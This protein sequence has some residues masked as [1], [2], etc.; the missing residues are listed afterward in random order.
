M[1]LRRLHKRRPRAKSMRYMIEFAKGLY[2][3]GS[4]RKRVEKML[5]TL[6]NLQSA[7]GRL[8]DIA[9][10]KAILARIAAERKFN[11]KD[12]KWRKPFRL[13]AMIF[14]DQEKVRSKQLDKVAEAFDKF[15][16][17]KPF[18]T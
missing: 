16:K 4:N 13:A 6:G 5:T 8:N 12:S 10:G 7:L 11:R 9:S 17:I 14:E 3:K 18:W 2:E 15:E 1:N